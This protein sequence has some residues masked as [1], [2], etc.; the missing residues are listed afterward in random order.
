MKI[1]VHTLPLAMIDEAVEGKVLEAVISG[2]GKDGT[3][4]CAT[5]P[6]KAWRAVAA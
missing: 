1:D 5:A 2:T 6:V 3:P 4:A